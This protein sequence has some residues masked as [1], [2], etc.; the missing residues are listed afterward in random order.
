M[1]L[2][3]NTLGEASVGIGICDRCK[4]KRPLG[5][6][7]PDGNSPG[8]RVC[9]DKPGCRD[10]FDPWRLPARRTEDIALRY[11]RPDVPLVPEPPTSLFQHVVVAS[12]GVLFSDQSES[13]IV[14]LF[15]SGVDSVAFSDSAVSD[16]TR[17]AE[18]SDLLALSD[19]ALSFSARTLDAQ[20]SGS[21]SDSATG[22]VQTIV[23]A[24]DSVTFADS[25]VAEVGDPLYDEVLL[26]LHG[27]GANNGS[28]FTDN[29]QYV[30]TVTRIDSRTFTSTVDS[31]FNG[32]S[33][34]S[35]GTGSG[36]LTLSVPEAAGR[37]W[38][39]EAW[40]KR[41]PAFDFFGLFSFASGNFCALF[42]GDAGGGTFKFQV[43]LS[44][45]LALE[46][47]SAISSADFV[48][49]AVTC[50]Q[51]SGLNNTVRMFVDG[52]LVASGVSTDTNLTLAGMNLQIGRESLSASYGI[53]GYFA[54]YRI[55]NATRYTASFSPPTA[56]FPNF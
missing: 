2:F 34:R 28:V 10:H 32:S 11:P 37:N 6:L 52:A 56:P 24:S 38:C 33:I 17:A 46:S 29:S 19:S 35:T 40:V 23:V 20:D 16:A 42:D 7:V 39:C 51:G 15:G 13:A 9:V 48:H 45:A 12:D 25:V 47:P 22:E 54:E 49:L 36:F 14:A 1:P 30:R 50:E 3:L 27:N 4:M 5:R 55:T 26:L 43:T 8:L 21:F 18:A 41:E 53:N 31:K 44:G